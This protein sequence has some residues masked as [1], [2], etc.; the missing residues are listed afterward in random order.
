M[1]NVLINPY[2][3]KNK[4]EYGAKIVHEIK[5][6]HSLRHMHIV[7]HRIGNGGLI[8]KYSELQ[9]S[10]TNK[11][12]SF[13]TKINSAS[14]LVVIK[15]RKTF[16]ITTWMPSIY[17][18]FLAFYFLLSFK[19]KVSLEFWVGPIPFNGLA[20]VFPDERAVHRTLGT[21]MRMKIWGKIRKPASKLYERLK[22]CSCHPGMR[23]CS[24]G[25]F[26]PYWRK[27]NNLK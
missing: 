16:L 20:R 18:C 11:D 10:V 13:L 24:P 1:P 17:L 21:K 3:R 8:T 7:A 14:C 9:K 27:R 15:P 4:F 12:L 23:G 2:R 26:W 19:C 25:I 22:T 6:V 5:K